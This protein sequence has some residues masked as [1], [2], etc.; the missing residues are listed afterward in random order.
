MTVICWSSPHGLVLFSYSEWGSGEYRREHR[1]ARWVEALYL[2]WSQK[3]TQV[4]SH[5][6]ILLQHH[7]FSNLPPVHVKSDSVYFIILLRNPS[8]LPVLPLFES[9]GHSV[10]PAVVHTCGWVCM[11]CWVKL[12][13]RSALTTAVFNL[14]FC[15]IQMRVAPC[16]VCQ[17]LE[18]VS[19]LAQTSKDS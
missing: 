4:S 2:H 9:F 5:T 13:R 10:A 6:F 19:F 3:Q 1:E 17:S 11:K 14:H 16:S 8:L 7:L 18:L 12:C 15:Q